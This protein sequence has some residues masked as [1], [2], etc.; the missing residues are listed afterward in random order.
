MCPVTQANELA[1]TVLD[2]VTGE[3]RTLPFTFDPF[4]WTEGNGSC[5]CNRRLM[6][7]PEHEPAREEG[8]C[9]GCE[10]Y[11]I[12]GVAPMPDGYTLDEFNEGYE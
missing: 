2:T 10:R 9:L 6:F 1:V 7:F 11:R 12:V 3:S 5:D 8:Y 4:W